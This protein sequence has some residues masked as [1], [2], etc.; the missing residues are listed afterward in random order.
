MMGYSFAVV[1]LIWRDPLA[2][3]DSSGLQPL[4]EAGPSCT[5]HLSVGLRDEMWRQPL[6]VNHA[7]LH[8]L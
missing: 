8:V 5:D 2:L 6:S 3:V 7:K 1:T 4:R